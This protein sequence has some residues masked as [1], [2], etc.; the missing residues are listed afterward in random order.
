MACWDVSVRLAVLAV[1]GLL[2]LPVPALAAPPPNDGPQAPAAFEVVTAANG[3]PAEQQGIAELAEA[4]ADPGVPSCLGAGSFARTVWFRVPEGP[5]P[6]EITVEASGSTLDVVDL[7]AF[8]QPAG[9]GS[10]SVG[11]PNQCGGVGAGGSD[12]SE[13]PTAAVTLRL[14]A[15][16]ALLIQVG[17]RG[18]AGGPAEERVLLSLAQATL[19]SIAAP[20]G[21]LVS[22]A[23]RA[24]PEG[25][26]RM[27]LGGATLAED[28][29]AQ[30]ACPAGASVWRRVV[31]P[32][33]GPR[34]ISVAG[35]AAGTL[36]VFS[37]ARPTLANALDCVNRARSGQLQMRVRARKG[38]PLWVRVGTDRPS[39]SS[40][41]RLRVTGREEPVVDGGPGGADPTAGGPGGG[42]P[43]ACDR[44]AAERARITGSGLSGTAAQRNRSRALVLRARLRGA[45]VCDVEA[46]L[47]GP[48]GRLYGIARSVRVRTGATRLRIVR[49]RRLVRGGYTVRVSALDR[50]GERHRLRG[51]IGGQLR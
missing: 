14:P 38:R 8:V 23:P 34:T 2:A 27:R 43:A 17:R 18:A 45:M 9:T 35:V 44:S 13:E 46:R 40:A 29:P 15:N 19:G 3:N 30:P 25:G 33:T 24:R 6:R 4:T 10:P 37:G 39:S 5:S 41:A 48:R 32:R 26:V 22:G 31:A 21:D 16:Q 28:D 20:A 49:T 51:R 42:L 47:V 36:T 50:F 1:L 12:A 11:L 7:A